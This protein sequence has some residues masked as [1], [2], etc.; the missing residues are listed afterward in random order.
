MYQ[1][2]FRHFL[3]T[4]ALALLVVLAGCT[5]TGNADGDDPS[6]D[7]D[8][9]EQRSTQHDSESD[10][11][12]CRNII[13]TI[14]ELEEAYDDGDVDDAFAKHVWGDDEDELEQLHEKASTFRSR[15]DSVAK[16]LD[17]ATFEPSHDS[18]PPYREQ[19]EEWLGYMDNEF[20]I[21]EEMVDKRLR[22]LRG[23]E[24]RDRGGLWEDPRQLRDAVL[25]TIDENFH[26]FRVW[27][28]RNHNICGDSR[29]E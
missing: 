13:T 22:D 17:D 1:H 5:S 25:M 11:S 27:R 7:S 23:D 6:S 10:D 8:T 21:L 26:E 28:M 2:S 4:F 12:T 29:N 15:F 20:R 19:L 16:K 24:V 3:R 18:E 14:N 9:S